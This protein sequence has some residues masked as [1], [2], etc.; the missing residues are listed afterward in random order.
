MAKIENKSH[1]STIRPTQLKAQTKTAN[2]CV[3]IENLNK[4]VHSDLRYCS[5]FILFLSGQRG[6]ATSWGEKKFEVHS[7]AGGWVGG[8]HEGFF[9]SL[10]RNLNA[11]FISK[12]IEIPSNSLFISSRITRCQILDI[13][14]IRTRTIYIF[15]ELI[16][17]CLNCNYHCNYHI[18]S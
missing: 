10:D 7:S 17:N 2:Y 18:F 15:L 1:L 3:T 12:F 8:G 16:C 9:M 11:Y 6:L 14:F 13:K 5:L 4:L